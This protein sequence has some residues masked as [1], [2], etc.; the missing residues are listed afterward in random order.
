MLFDYVQV[1]LDLDRLYKENINLVSID[2]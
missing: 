1:V 2:M